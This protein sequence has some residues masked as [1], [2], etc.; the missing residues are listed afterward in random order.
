MLPVLRAAADQLIM[1]VAMVEYVAASVTAA[2]DAGEV[3]AAAFLVPVT[4]L[5]VYI[6]E[7]ASE[8]ARFL[9]GAPAVLPACDWPLAGASTAA[10]VS[11]DESLDA[12][13]AARDDLIQVLARVAR[14]QEGRSRS[15]E[16]A[17]AFMAR[18][19]AHIS[20]HAFDLIDAAPR[21]RDDGFFL[22]WAL[23]PGLYDAPD[24]QARRLSFIGA[25]AAQPDTTKED[26]LT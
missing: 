21:L 7:C 6:E 23:W 18:A 26:S 2:A 22:N 20:H 17:V 1:D 3:S 14:T 12:L 24:L 4:H 8:V 25:L 19:S 5:A 11:L 16:S 10:A 9:D 13:A 15:G